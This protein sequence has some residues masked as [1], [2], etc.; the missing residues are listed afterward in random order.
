[1]DSIWSKLLLAAALAAGGLSHCGGGGA[2]DGVPETTG[3]LA[4]REDAASEVADATGP[5]DVPDR[6]DGGRASDLVEVVD[7]PTDIGAPC[8][9]DDDCSGSICLGWLPGGYCTLPDCGPDNPCPEGAMCAPLHHDG[10]EFDACLKLCDMPEDC[11]FEDGYACDRD[12]TC[13]PVES[14]L[15]LHP[16]GESCILDTQCG[17]DFGAV[18]YP[19]Y[20]ANQPTGFTDGYCI[21]WECKQNGCPP[22]TKC[23]DVNTST[24]ACFAE[25]ESEDDCR[26]GYFCQTAE[27]VCL[28]GCESALD[29]PQKHVCLDTY[30]LESSFACSVSNPAGWCPDNKWCDEGNCTGKVFDC[31]EKQ[32]LEPNDSQEEAALLEQRRTFGLKVCGED[33]D[34]YRVET[35]AGRL[36]E[37]ELVFSNQAGNLDMLVYDGAGEFIRSRW[38]NYPYKGLLVADFDVSNESVSFYPPEQDGEVLVKIIGAE[39]AENNYGM[40]VRRYPYED[41]EQCDGPFSSE[42]C[43][44]MPGGVLKLY[45]FP[46][47]ESGDPWGGDNYHFETVSGYK[48]ARRELI[49]LIRQTLY[50][51][52][53]EYPGTAS[54]GIIDACQEDGV[55][56][57]YNIGQPRHCRTCHD[58]GGNIDLA[59]FATDGNN[60]VKTIC[61][62]GG[63]NVTA[64]GMQCTSAAKTEHIVDLER[65]VFFMARLFDSPRMRAIGV[66]PVIA[67]LLGAKADEMFSAG[68]ISAQG[69]FGIKNYLGLW[70]THHHHIHVSLKWW[71]HI[72]PEAQ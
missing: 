64:D 68:K 35:P 19:E 28:A 12:S 4:P 70:P 54:V 63:E 16:E 26:P 39:G 62:P 59:Y 20:Y 2:G 15:V 56:P 33:E 61:G 60:H 50:E 57:G 45:Q 11:R 17:A 67:P 69:R 7:S 32:A 6:S 41:G 71:D 66:D 8:E 49:M 30:C 29:C 43:S 38:I 51:T 1:M 36:T 21:I 65:Q 47:P 18:C 10:L 5:A 3:D 25:C 42:D 37:V 24:S 53:E 44:G 46:E 22:G 34:W 31:T 48:W 13:W 14:G 9:S 23:M 72:Y 27:K 52:V 58:E 55:T 40:V